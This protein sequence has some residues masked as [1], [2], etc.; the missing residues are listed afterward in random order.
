MV[1]AVG[2][3]VPEQSVVSGSAQA[4]HNRWAA[5][6]L[7]AALLSCGALGSLLQPDRGPLTFSRADWMA[8]AAHPGETTRHRMAEKLVS[9]ARLVSLSGQ[10]ASVMLGSPDPHTHGE[11]DMTWVLGPAR[12]GAGV[13]EM[14]AVRFN[15][16]GLIEASEIV[17]S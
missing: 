6:A 9:E 13:T 16:V 8:A 11:W 10:E 17:R 12:G 14:L 2:A 4:I 1:A 7:A 15:E 3:A 5:L